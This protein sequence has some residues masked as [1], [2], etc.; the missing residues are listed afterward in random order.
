MLCQGN[1]LSQNICCHIEQ[2]R[3][4]RVSLS[5]TF[6]ARKVWANNIIDFHTQ[7]SFVTTFFYPDEPVI[8]KTLM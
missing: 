4:K 2:E 8:T 3:G 5:D 1:H 7:G 6:T